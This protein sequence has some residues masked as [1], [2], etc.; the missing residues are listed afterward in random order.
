MGIGKRKA[1]FCRSCGNEKTRTV[2]GGRYHYY[3]DCAAWKETLALL[4]L[5]RRKDEQRRLRLRR[6]TEAVPRPAALAAAV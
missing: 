2:R 4:D 6:P 3:C 1:N 5:A